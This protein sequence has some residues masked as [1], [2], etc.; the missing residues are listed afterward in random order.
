MSTVCYCGRPDCSV[1]SMARD[2]CLTTLRAERDALKAQ[3]ADL[4]ERR[5]PVL[6]AGFS[7]PWRLVAPFETQAQRNHSQTLQRLAERGGLDPVELWAVMHGMGWR[8][9]SKLPTQEAAKA[10]ALSLCNSTTEVAT[11]RA[12]IAKM[13][14]ELAHEKGGRLDEAA[15]RAACEQETGAWPYGRIIDAVV[16]TLRAQQARWEAFVEAEAERAKKAEARVAELEARRAASASE[17]L[18]AA[19]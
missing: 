9:R 8:D 11:L 4:E 2:A 13:E 15:I 3:V 16:S 6:D 14:D 17:R 10:W 1:T 12:R 7:V 19:S 18:E 5:F